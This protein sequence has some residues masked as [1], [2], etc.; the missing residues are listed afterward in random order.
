MKTGKAVL[1]ALAGIA[2]GAIAGILFA[3]KKGSL[4]RKQII[5]KGDEYAVKL[6]SSANKMQGSLT[7]KFKR[8]K[9]HTDELVDKEQ[10]KHAN[11]QKDI[12]HVAENLKTDIAAD[13]KHFS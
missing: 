12:K 5:D 7:E 11:F 2:A 6:K 13:I 8:S 3:P 9:K 10:A 1:G 4:T